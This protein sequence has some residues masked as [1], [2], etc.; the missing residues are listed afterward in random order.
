MR[1]EGKVGLVYGGASGI[2]QGCAE[3]LSAEGASVVVADISEERGAEVVAGI[4][5]AGGTA[6]FVA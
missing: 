6:S 1:V 4:V 3:V 5:E 2:G